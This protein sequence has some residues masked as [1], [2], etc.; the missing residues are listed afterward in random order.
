MDKMLDTEEVVVKTKK[1][2]SWK[3]FFIYLAL[4]IV[5]RVYVIEP[6]T[7]SGTSMDNTFHTNDYVLVDKISYNFI[8]PKRGDVIVF[9]PPIQDR[10][11]DRFIKRIIG[12]P[13]DTVVVNGSE[14][15]VNGVKQVEN[16]VTYQSPRTASTTL[17]ADEY[18]VMG[19]NRAVSY[20]SRSWGI[21]KKE[22]IQ[23]RVVLRLYPFNQ[24]GFL[25]GSIETGTTTQQ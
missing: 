19:D 23:G 16:F 8:D 20:D 24:I 2:M 13:G 25:P 17:K 22:H 15:F 9:N 7:V 10:T 14:T 21:L 5:F 1:D 3:S 6:H 4:I 18:F 11:A 12:I